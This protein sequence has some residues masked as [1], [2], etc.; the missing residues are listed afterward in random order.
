MST[1]EPRGCLAAAAVLLLLLGFLVF[2]RAVVAVLH[3]NGLWSGIKGGYTW[4]SPWQ[5]VAASFL[6]LAMGLYVLIN[7]IW[8]RRR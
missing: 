7:A 3:H 2:V 8:N 5:L 1:W 6:I 4:M